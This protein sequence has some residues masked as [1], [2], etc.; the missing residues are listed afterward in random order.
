MSLIKFLRFT[1]SLR[2]GKDQEK[3]YAEGQDNLVPDFH[4]SGSRP[5]SVAEEPGRMSRARNAASD[6]PEARPGAGRWRA[7]LSGPRPAL[8]ADSKGQLSLEFVK[9]VRNDLS[10]ADLE[11]I[12][13]RPVGGA[14]GS[15]RS[16][17]EK[18]VVSSGSPA[19][20]PAIEPEVSRWSRFTARLFRS[21]DP[22]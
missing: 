12:P 14:E 3:S 7:G 13:A 8:R 2:S 9:V 4:R 19:E 16:S 15:R 20:M 17:T 1:R 11:L 10:D 6:A 22:G 21:P 5:A 18:V